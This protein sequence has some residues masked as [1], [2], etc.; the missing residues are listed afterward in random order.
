MRSWPVLSQSRNSS[1]TMEPE[2]SWKHSQRS[3]NCPYPGPSRSSPKVPTYH[4]LKLHHNI[5]LPSTTRSSKWSLFLRFPHQHPVYALLSIICSTCPAHLILLDF[6]TWTISGEE[7]RSLSSSLCSF[8][9][10]P[11][12]SSLLGSSNLL[13]TLFS[14]TLTLCSSLNVGDQFQHQYNRKNYSSV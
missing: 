5:Y 2:G 11:V 1:H 14:N 10:C 6:I 9:H 12:T 7:Q 8:L 3:A 13:S 4:F